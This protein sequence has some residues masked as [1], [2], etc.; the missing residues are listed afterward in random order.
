MTGL[1]GAPK[2]LSVAVLTCLLAAL[3]AFAPQSTIG[4]DTDDPIAVL[5]AR[6]EAGAVTITADDEHGYLK[7]LLDELD[8]PVSSQGLVFSRT[9]L[10]T[11]RIGPWAP[12]ALYFNDD[13]YIGWV[14]DSPILEIASID[15]DEGSYFYTVNQD[16][17]TRPVFERQ[18]TTCLMC[19]ESRAVTEGVPGV[20]M[21]SVLTD[22]LGYVIGS[23]QEGSVTDRTPFSDRLGGFYVTGTHGT[24]SHSGNT[25]SPLL[26]HEVSRSRDYLETF[27]MTA[28]G[29]VTDLEG[30]FDVSRYLSPHSDVT[31]LLVLG[32]Q[33]RVHNLI[34]LAR[35]TA[36]DALRD[37][38]ID[39][40]TTGGT[41]PA[42]GLLP[43][44]QRRID[45]VLNR[46]LREMLFVHEA[47][48]N[49]P[50]R[51]TSDYASEFAAMGPADSQGRSLRE[52]DLNQ[53]LFRYPLS[54]L[55]Y[56]TAFDTLP[57]IAKDRF[58]GRLDAVLTGKDADP[59]F[60]H[61]T[62]ADR[63]A[64]REILED[65]KPDFVARRGTAQ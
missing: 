25:M 18:T 44:A 61:L 9:S 26:G 49:G 36:E 2:S 40:L 55:I 31:A 30:R 6:I 48:L 15:P 24:P 51:G 1:P 11:D 4:P 5:D 52:L 13:V 46:L 29:N 33:A 12:R 45:G 58:Y 23:L 53:R 27:D 3:Y 14:V 62:D 43:A 37:Q 65:T 32:H 57:D 41:A 22:R 64:I 50:V 56:T 54:F 35:Q 28:N 63:T 59:D 21:R 38:E 10:Q 60:G 47:P 8:V 20:I 39:L 19:H 16:G 17:G 7:G 34:I 42:S